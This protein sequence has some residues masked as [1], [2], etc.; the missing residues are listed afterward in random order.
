MPRHFK[1]HI[2]FSKVKY[3]REGS[4][5]S[6]FKM[7]GPITFVSENRGTKLQLNL[8]KIYIYEENN[9]TNTSYVSP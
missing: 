3:L 6:D 7:G 2:T 8:N 1:Y 5:L 9:N 4:K